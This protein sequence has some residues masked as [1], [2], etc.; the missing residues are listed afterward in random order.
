MLAPLRVHFQVEG[1]VVFDIFLDDELLF[2]E[3]L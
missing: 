1:L 2:D 3:A